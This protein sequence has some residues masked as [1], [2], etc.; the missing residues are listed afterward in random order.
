MRR[1]DAPSSRLVERHRGPRVID[2]SGVAVSNSQADRASVPDPTTRQFVYAG[3]PVKLISARPLP[4]R[5]NA[6]SSP[7]ATASN[8]LRPMSLSSQKA[9]HT[10]PLGIG[11]WPATIAK[12]LTRPALKAPAEVI[13]R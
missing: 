2:T 5:L 9:R 1:A 8:T 12:R 6:H 13:I 7:Q 11:A 4:P 3:F 10:T